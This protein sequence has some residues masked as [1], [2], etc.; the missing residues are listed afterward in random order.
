MNRAYNRS[1]TFVNLFLI[2]LGFLFGP[3][4]VCYGK[5]GC[6]QDQPGENAW[7]VDLPESPSA[8]GTSFHMF[9]RDGFGIVD[10]VDESK[11][12]A[13]NFDIS[14]RTIFVIHGYTGKYLL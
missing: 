5:Y 10:D 3:D 2:Y 11:L 12:I 6:F 9:T 7:L 4:E 14:R 8:V 1:P 13:P